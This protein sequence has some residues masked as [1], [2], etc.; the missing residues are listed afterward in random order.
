MPLTFTRIMMNQNDLSPANRYSGFILE[1][2]QP[3]T[4]LRTTAYQFTHEKSGAK[5]LHLFNDDPNNLFS[6]AFRTPVSDSTGVPHI[7]EHSV[8][9]GSRAFPL[10]DP[11]QELL[12]GSLQTFLNALTYPDKTLY[13]VSSQVEADFFNLVH[14]YCDAVFCPL[15]SP[16]TFRQEGW[17]FE[18]DSEDGRVGIKGIV[19]NEMKGVFSDFA[20]HVE[21]KTMSLLFPNT[22]YFHESGGE[23]LH[24]TD[25][26][27]EQ[28]RAFHARYYHP[29]NSLVVLYGNIPSERTL[30]FLD[31]KYLSSFDKLPGRVE[32][33][34]QPD[35]PAPRRAEV[36]APA[37]EQDD[38]LATVA[39]AWKFGMSAD[40]QTSLL[41][42]ILYQYLM[43]TESG[44]LRRAL[45]DS[46]L[47]E[48]LDDICGFSNELVHGM[49]CV[50]LRKS[51]P[52][53]AEAVESLVLS[54]LEKQVAGGIDERLLEG[55]IRLIE[56][57]LREIADAGR[58]PYNLQLAER[59]LRSWL[60][61][62]DP[63][64]HL[65]F[66]KPLSSIRAEKER[67]TG[68][69]AQK[70]GELLVR[71][72][73]RLRVTVR[74]SSAMGKKLETQSQE[75]AAALSAGFSKSDRQRIVEETR[76]LVEEQ[77][78][79][80]PPEALAK[81]PKLSKLDLPP[82]NREVPVTLVRTAGIETY[83]HPLFTSGIVYCDIGFDCSAVPRELL[84]YLPLYL[85]LLTR[86]G[87]AGLSYEEMAKRA[88]LSTG[89]IDASFLCDTSVA[90]GRLVFLAFVHAKSLAAR[91]GET[92][93]I[94][95]DILLAPDFSNTKQIKD[96]LIEMRNNLNAS[97]I[98]AGH[99]FAVLHASADISAASRV[100]ET[101]GGITQL[102][103]LDGLAAADSASGVAAAIKKVHAAVVS[104]AGSV[105]SITADDPREA[106]NAIAPVLRA[107][108]PDKAP[109]LPFEFSR[110]GGAVGIEISS[111]VNFAAKSWG[112]G[113]QEPGR[114]GVLLLLSRNL[115][116][117]YLWDKV[118]V[119]GGAYGGMAMLSGGE[120]VFSC[121]SYRDPNLAS[122]YSH[123]EK[124]LRE[125]AAGLPA[126][127]VDQS[128][129]G[130]IGKT[131]APR[132]PHEKGFAETAAL[133]CGRTREYRQ[134]VRDGVLFA[135]PAGLAEAAKA[136]LSCPR[137]STAAL[138]GGAA[139]DK[140][141]KEGVEMKREP[142]L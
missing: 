104:S 37:P 61:G 129:I 88:A 138:G 106:A 137:F 134:A 50:G 51:R 127:A 56:F 124:G 46:G 73:H 33:A 120:A 43:G 44:P 28:F 113:R 13:P 8:L 38:G 66:E 69:F 87:A 75:Q 34:V 108:P 100:D 102:R 41:G 14:V 55:A 53:R 96:V 92:A 109:A 141:E 20:S 24:I 4:E 118:R 122:T 49:F 121:A 25:L 98:N 72:P 99:S 95:R 18:L 139:F 81:L 11:F 42:R 80:V 57:R 54:T 58:F 94:L 78:K 1:R 116:T 74:A 17:H 45:V 64:A 39:L 112:L 63:L 7:L 131:D 115:S 10:K 68:W 12:K 101:L 40:A 83:L 119:E 128:I 65:A 110:Q 111:S 117:G 136:V 93:D 23:P 3:V 27:L 6:I 31:E 22:S 142:L 91:F 103:F 70:I 16:S 114:L 59:S 19:Y 123:F 48:D 107:L 15:L 21:R 26:T 2:V 82:K 132:T 62:G 90:D 89:G 67:G 125:A 60:Y 30:A 133:L 77:K 5:L 126:G 86:C 105:L 32:I 135:S 29:S 9:G 52:E 35:W 85:N 84:P 47:G 140:A 97:V 36:E 130:T 79:P 76:A 71:N